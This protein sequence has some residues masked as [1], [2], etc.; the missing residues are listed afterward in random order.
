MSAAR[1][2]ARCTRRRRETTRWQNADTLAATCAGGRD[3]YYTPTNAPRRRR[4]YPLF[5]K[6]APV[7][8]AKPHPVVFQL[9]APLPLVPRLIPVRHSRT[10]RR[11]PPPVPEAE[12][13]GGTPRR[14]P[15]A[16]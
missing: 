11:D 10:H 14:S 6:T 4:S 2:F 3:Y 16:M 5:I 15:V 7:L 13:G 9:C 12:A 1:G 8:A